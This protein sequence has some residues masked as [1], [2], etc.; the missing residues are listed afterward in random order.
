MVAV[1]NTKGCGYY[2]DKGNCIVN[3]GKFE[4]ERLTQDNF[5]WV[6]QNGKCGIVKFNDWKNVS[7]ILY[8]YLPTDWNVDAHE[9]EEIV[10]EKMILMFLSD[11]AIV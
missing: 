7:S 8:K 6:K 9:D 1:K 10:E 3:C 5:A 11:L 4:E 2:D